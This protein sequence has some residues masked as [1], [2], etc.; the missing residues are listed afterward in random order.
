M[1]FS[2][3]EET[4][5]A[6]VKPVVHEESPQN[7]GI[8]IVDSTIG[9]YRKLLEYFLQEIPDHLRADQRVHK[10]IELLNDPIRAIIMLRAISRIIRRKILDTCRSIYLIEAGHGAGL[11]AAAAAV[12]HK[13]IQVLACDD[14]QGC[15]DLLA[16]RAEKFGLSERIRIECRDLLQKP[17]TE[18]ADVVVAEHLTRG[19]FFE[20]SSALPRSVRN[21]D[22][23]IFVP[24]A[25]RPKLLIESSDRQY[26]Y[27]DGTEVVL[28][29]NNVPGRFDVSGSALLS[30]GVTP[31]QVA[32]D[33]RWLSPRFDASGEFL[34]VIEGSED[35]HKKRSDL[36]APAIFGNALQGVMATIVNHA[37]FPV[38]SLV[39]VSY[40]FG[41]LIFGRN[42]S[43]L[44]RISTSHPATRIWYAQVPPK[45]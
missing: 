20:H 12:M 19:C 40:P 25:V 24:Y 4:F 36:A 22:P 39:E 29:D 44:L 31:I 16:N 6:V 7:S 28:A 45:T 9:Y 35:P 3:K 21:V 27:L 23:N 34:E 30:P 26:Q 13:D 14:S 1:F 33:I 5:E 42:I 37:P 8:N 10:A 32:N 2:H 38:F 15:A 17:L 18:A 43:H 11:M 41:V